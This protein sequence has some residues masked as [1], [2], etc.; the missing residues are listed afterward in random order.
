MIKTL[1]EV[2][3]Y[4]Y[5]KWLTINCDFYKQVDPFKK[6]CASC[7]FYKAV[8]NYEFANSW[9]KNKNVYS[10]EFL[11]TKIDVPDYPYPNKYVEIAFDFTP[12][13]VTFTEFINAKEYLAI[14]CYEKDELRALNKEIKRRKLPWKIKNSYSQDDC[15]TNRGE[16]ISKEAT[17]FYGMTRLAFYLIDLDK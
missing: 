12:K 11:D 15:H 13:E 6:E 17:L 16:I 14:V 9:Y 10:K 2:G 4:D 3:Q 5:A 7:P 8:C 1:N